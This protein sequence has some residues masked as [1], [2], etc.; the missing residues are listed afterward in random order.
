MD[1]MGGFQEDQMVLEGLQAPRGHPS[2]MGKSFLRGLVV[3][4]QGGTVTL[5]VMDPDDQAG[6]TV[7]GDR[8]MGL[9]RLEAMGL[10]MVIHPLIETPWRVITMTLG[11]PI[12]PPTLTACNVLD[13]PAVVFIK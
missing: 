13:D 12:L 2:H 1:G 6:A 7:Q 10:L 3:P 5:G 4:D 11:T 8:E 9:I